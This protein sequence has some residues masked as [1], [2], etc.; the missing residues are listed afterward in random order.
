MLG[1]SEGKLEKLKV[2][3]YKDKKYSKD[4]REYETLINPE[5][6]SESYKIE[7][8]TGKSSGE[9]GGE[10]KFN[11]IAPQT[12]NLRFIFD[13]TG[14]LSSK[15]VPDQV[16]DFMSVVFDYDGDSHQPRYVKIIWGEKGK[17]DLFKGRLDSVDIKYTLFKP[18]GTPIRATAS[19]ALTASVDKETENLKKKNSSPDL[20]HVRVVK[21]GDTLPLMTYGIYGDSLYY[22]EVARVNKLRSVRNLKVGTKLFFPPIDKKSA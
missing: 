20:T 5:D 19:A 17:R 16:S 8:T 6:F 14:I 3:S 21:E 7:Y 13:S 15:S 22:M 18:D 10:K 12:V 9:S 1:F 4:E 2:Y 11:R